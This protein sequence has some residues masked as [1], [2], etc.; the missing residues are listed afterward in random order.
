M[1]V[2]ACFKRLPCLVAKLCAAEKRSGVLLG[3]AATGHHILAV[4]GWCEILVRVLNEAHYRGPL[5]L[6]CF[7]LVCS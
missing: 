5:Q 7:V 3:V 4:F 2:W 1:D 6:L